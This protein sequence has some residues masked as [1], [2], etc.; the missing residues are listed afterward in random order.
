MRF[1]APFV[2]GGPLF[3]SHA[4]PQDPRYGADSL[5]RLAALA[6]EAGIVGCCACAT[7]PDD[8]GQ[9]LAVSARLA[10][11]GFQV[12]P[13]VGVHPWHASLAPGSWRDGLR[14]LLAANPDAIVGEAGLDGIRGAPREDQE[15][16]LAA[17]LEIAA[18]L[19]R[20][21]ILHG[22]GA[23]GAVAAA[24]RPFAGRIPYFVAHAFGGSV[25]TMRELV[26]MG[27]RISFGG[28]ACN[29]GAKRVRAAVAECP[30]ERLLIETDAPDM[31]PKNG[32]PFFADGEGGAPLNG[33]QN[34]PLVAAA[35]AAIRA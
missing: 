4:H 13:A 24:L 23:W 29:P 19:S 20:G 25:E 34:L 27:G 15:A 35:V 11:M 17:Q 28:A 7:S 1:P 26:A 22:A 12:V 32:A 33:P 9:T 30:A 2:P 14:A 18:E 10:E 8:W 16:A 31:A 21:V 6:R 3:D 5:G